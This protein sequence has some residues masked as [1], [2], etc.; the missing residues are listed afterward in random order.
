MASDVARIC[1]Q[2]PHS[3]LEKHVHISLLDEIARDLVEWELLAPSISL[4]RA[5]QKEIEE[6]YAGQYYLQKREALRKWRNKL[7]SAA[8]VRSLIR[9]LCE[10]KLV[11]VAEIVADKC[12]NQPACITVFAEYLCDFYI[13]KFSHPLKRQWPGLHKHFDLPPVYFDLK[14]HEVPLEEM[15]KTMREVQLSDVFQ[16]SSNRLVTL[17]EGV[18]GSGKTTLSWHACREW[19]N[20]KLL[21][22]FRLL[23]HVQVNKLQNTSALSDLI[24]DRDKEAR[25]ELAQA[26]VDTR[27][28]GVC[29]FLEG[30]DEAS[31]DLLDFIL[32]HLLCNKDLPQLSFIIT[33]RPDSRLFELQGLL[34]SKIVIDGFTY[35][36]LNTFLVSAVPC[37][38]VKETK[39]L[40]EKSPQLQT[41]CTLPINAV[42]VSFLVQCYKDEIPIT[43][44]ELFNLLFCHI[45]IRHMQRKG[46]KPTKVKQLPND[47]PSYL[48]KS[49]DKL[50]LLAFT[51]LQKKKKIFTIDDVRLLNLQDEVEDKLGILQIHQTFT[52]YGLEEYY[53]FP[54]LALQQFLAAINLSQQKDSEQ[55]CFIQK[56]IKEDPLDELLPFLAGLTIDRIRAKIVK[57]LNCK[58]S[59]DDN[60]VACELSKNP[61][62]S[63]DPRRKTLALFKCLY[64]CQ[65]ESLLAKVQLQIETI[66]GDPGIDLRYVI[67][68]W[69]MWMSPLECLAVGYFVRYKSITM[70]E[71]RSLSLNL[72][73]C[74]ISDTGMSVLTKELRRGVNYRTPGRIILLLAEN[75]LSISSLLSVKELL[76]GQSNIE[77][78]G[79]QK[80]FLSL[81]NK[82]YLKHII[83]GLCRNSS[84]CHTA[85][86]YNGLNRS[87][88]H[89]L[90]L[91]I[92]SCTQ[93]H[94]I[95]LS[96]CSFCGVMPLLSKAFSLSKLG[97]LHLNNCD[98]DDEMLVSLG[99]EISQNPHLNSI[100][101]Y[102]NRFTPDGLMNFVLYFANDVSIMKAIF[103][104]PWQGILF[105][106]IPEMRYSNALQHVI[107]FRKQHNRPEFYLM[108]AGL[109]ELQK[110]N[111]T[112]YL[113]SLNQPKLSRKNPA[114]D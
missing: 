3:V 78:V 43:Q 61:I 104:D 37:S 91:L 11:D 47:L 5:E 114:S 87:H 36:M 57:H 2:I 112:N 92:R 109:A 85:I 33:S 50:C 8:T 105:R 111:S 56:L 27:G 49:F 14:L 75:K 48:R 30:I 69:N 40:I 110:A 39:L 97:G 28:E 13:N 32:S 46:D 65:N 18:A 86:G 70:P 55:K 1:K 77:G 15:S 80:C 74:S 79:L 20:Q 54:H 76:K 106:I 6:N 31:N 23:I 38:N 90:I 62:E 19:A 16:G 100:E 59:L 108:S 71:R 12:Q 52:M 63:N 99:K 113:S 84:C 34:S 103:V 60:T 102:N 66:S 82:V 83:E 107:D 25:D 9:I 72:G 53:S 44:T 94:L 35:E 98:I 93:L 68:F 45:C 7:K 17:F 22:R 26:I 101:I 10:Q 42:V 41:L 73:K 96:G 81:D 58:M 64:E 4:T 21:Q 24:P 51:A 67:T 88:I 95:N 29:F 89:H